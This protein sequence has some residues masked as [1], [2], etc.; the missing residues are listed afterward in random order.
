VGKSSVRLYLSIQ[1]DDAEV[2]SRPSMSGDNLIRRFHDELWRNESIRGRCCFLMMGLV[3][4]IN[5][6]E[7]AARLAPT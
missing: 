1:V 2:L 5:L 3:P 7:M 4:V 6:E